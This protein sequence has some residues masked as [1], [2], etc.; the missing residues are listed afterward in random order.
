MP[1]WISIGKKPSSEF[2]RGNRLLVGAD[3]VKTE[4]IFRYNSCDMNQSLSIQIHNDLQRME[5]L[6]GIVEFPIRPSLEK[7]DEILQMRDSSKTGVL[8]HFPGTPT[9]DEAEE[10]MSRRLVEEIIENKVLIQE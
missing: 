4:R 7:V 2:L 8:G 3:K 5:I 1:M 10:I 6:L 9:T